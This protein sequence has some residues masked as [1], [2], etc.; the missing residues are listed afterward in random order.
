M[1]G[2]HSNFPR[3]TDTEEWFLLGAGFIALVMFVKFW[4]QG[5]LWL[6][7]RRVLLPAR[8]HPMVIVPGT[9][10][11]GLDFARFAILV[12]ALLAFTAV[13]VTAIRRRQA[14]ADTETGK[15]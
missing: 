3:L 10:G 11:A 7:S 8:A 6:I 13:A 5:V 9:G 1:A 4:H 2:S 12:A 15:S 14:K